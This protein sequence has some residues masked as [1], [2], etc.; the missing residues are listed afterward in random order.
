MEV[1]K[2]VSA[3]TGLGIA[4]LVVSGVAPAYAADETVNPDEVVQTIQDVGPVSAV[5]GE[6]VERTDM[7]LIADVNG[8]QVSIPNDPKAGIV[9]GTGDAAVAVGLPFSDKADSA[10]MPSESG[11]AVYDNN[12]SSHTVPIIRDDGGV[13]ITTVIENASAPRK[14]AYPISLPDGLTLERGVN[15][16]VSATPAGSSIPA[17]YV[18]APWAKD[19]NG[20][21][22]H[23][24]YEV[25][26]NTITQVVDFSEQSSFPIVADPA[27]YVDYTTASV[28]NVS[29]LGTLTRW[30]FLNSCTAA[31]GRTCSVSRA[32]Q[33][34]A[35]VQT[36][37]GVSYSVISGSINV[38]NG[39]TFQF[40]ATCGIPNGPGTASLYAQADKTSYQV[41]T[42][43]RWGVPTAGGGSMHEETKVSGTLYAYKPNLRYSCV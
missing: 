3:L 32:Y 27:T 36:S 6:D 4:I 18:A 1:R 5:G 7:G 13:Q 26:G 38:T 14:Y 17:L 42:V 2:S 41:R 34:T 31:R 37:L 39:E 29:R 43:R 22:V 15:G 16:D 28:T 8:L 11:V 20:D 35:T 10:A 40:T 25:S 23:T 12:N 30:Q 9:L 21:P 24:H 19:A 33:V